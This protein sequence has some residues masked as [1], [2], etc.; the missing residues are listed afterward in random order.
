[1]E[2]LWSCARE[3]KQFSG[4]LQIVTSLSPEI[5]F[6]WKANLLR[7]MSSI[8]WSGLLNHQKLTIPCCQG[9]TLTPYHLGYSS[10]EKHTNSASRW[11]WVIVTLLSLV[12]DIFLLLISINNNGFPGRSTTKSISTPSLVM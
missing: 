8:L 12:K 3:E 11:L 6:M 10:L 7:W 5:T 9:S 4:A 1:M 2:A